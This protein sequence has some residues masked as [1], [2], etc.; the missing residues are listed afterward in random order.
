MRKLIMLSTVLCIA[1][2]SDNQ[3][4]TSPAS[5]SGSRDIAQTAE[6][7]AIAKA[8]GNPHGDVVGFTTITMV[9][10]PLTTVLAANEGGSQVLCPA[11]SFVTGGG[12]TLGPANQATPPI[13]TF[14][15]MLNGLQQGWGVGLVNNLP[16]AADVEVQ[17]FVHCAS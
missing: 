14:N 3:Q 6:P 5:R 4:P 10:G 8:N 17:A 16:G 11:G 13:V 9:S 7:T 12:Y 2:C 1:A 15:R